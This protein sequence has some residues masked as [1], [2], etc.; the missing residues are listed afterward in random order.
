MQAEM[1]RIVEEN[2]LLKQQLAQASRAAE[3]NDFDIN[4]DHFSR[5]S[6]LRVTPHALCAMLYFV[7]ILIGC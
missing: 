4:L 6:L 2:E 7:Q 1:Q 5:I 3:Y